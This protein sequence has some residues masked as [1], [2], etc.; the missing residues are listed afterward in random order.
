VGFFALTTVGKNHAPRPVWEKRKTPAN[1]EIPPIEPVELK[2]TQYAR[3]EG[4]AW[5]LRGA[6]RRRGKGHAKGF[7]G[8]P[9]FAC[10]RAKIMVK[11]SYGCLKTSFYAFS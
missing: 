8:L 6:H 10:Q 4:L 7:Y 9:V 2:T 11:W 3:P 1:L 5:P